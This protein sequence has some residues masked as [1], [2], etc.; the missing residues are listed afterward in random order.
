M[1]GNREV[2]DVQI[3]GC[4]GFGLFGAWLVGIVAAALA[5]IPRG[6]IA[7]GQVT[8]NPAVIWGV[9]S[10]VQR[11]WIATAVTWLAV[12]SLGVAAWLISH[13]FSV[14]RADD[15][16]LVPRKPAGGWLSTD[17]RL[18]LGAP[19]LVVIGGIAGAILIS[20]L[21][22]LVLAVPLA[23]GPIAGL[24]MGLS[25]TGAEQ[26]PGDRIILGAPEGDDRHWVATR[27]DMSAFLL[28][29]PSSGKTGGL[30]IPNLLA[31]D[32][33]A[34]ATSTKFDVLA[35]TARRRLELGGCWVWAPLDAE[36]ALPAGVHRLDYSPI[37][38]AENWGV[39]SRHAHA[40]AYSSGDGESSK[41]WASSA[42][43][44][45]AAALHAAAISGE[46]MS[47]VLEAIK[48]ADWRW[49]RKTLEE[50][51][52]ANPQARA[53]L[54]SLEGR[55]ATFRADMSAN[56]DQALSLALSG[57]LVEH[58]GDT[59]DWREFLGGRSTL[60]IV[61]PTELP[62]VDPAPWVNVLLAD[63]VYSVRQASAANG[64]RL[65][66][67][68]LMLLDELGALCSLDNL[69]SL[70]ATQRA[71]GMSFLLAAQSLAQIDRRYGQSGSRTIRDAVGAIVLGMG[72]SDDQALRDMEELVGGNV[73]LQQ[74]K[75]RADDP[76]V[77]EDEGARW[78]KHE[79]ASLR[80]YH[81]YA[82]L[83]GS[84]KPRHVR[85]P[86]FLDPPF[87]QLW[88]G[89]APVKGEEPPEGEAPEEEDG[90]LDFT[91][92]TR[93]VER[94]G[95]AMARVPALDRAANAWVGWVEDIWTRI[96]MPGLQLQLA[97]AA[98]QLEARMRGIEIS[99]RGQGINLAGLNGIRPL[100]AGEE[101]PRHEFS[102]LEEDGSISKIE[103]AGWPQSRF[104]SEAP[105]TS[106][107]CAAEEDND[108]LEDDDD[109]FP[110]SDAPQSAKSG[111]ARPQKVH[112]AALGPH[113]P[114]GMI[115]LLQQA[116]KITIDV[117]HTDAH[118]V[119]D[120]ADGGRQ[121]GEAGA[122]EGAGEALAGGD[123]AALVKHGEDAGQGLGAPMGATPGGAT[124]GEERTGLIGRALRITERPK[125]VGV[126][127]SHPDHQEPEWATAQREYD[128]RCQLQR[129]QEARAGAASK[130]RPMRWDP[131]HASIGIDAEVIEPTQASTAP[132]PA[133]DPGPATEPQRPDTPASPQPPPPSDPTATRR[134]ASFAVE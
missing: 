89:S 101:P 111:S 8:Q 72:V 97:S 127:R 93:L 49:L 104:H 64:Y 73:S 112:N 132:D 23:A 86:Y 11:F 15:P 116:R 5:G 120:A 129:E 85:A 117:K 115:Q 92:L 43:Q 83:K 1:S 28:G 123:E 47:R 131:G 21:A 38:G 74:R 13:R 118:E 65:P 113:G 37:S 62:H 79:I 30:I 12:I 78:A 45:I 103:V 29:S 98:E 108:G 76:K 66:H 26:I 90:R 31:W 105:Q 44:L 75:G 34:V 82:H 20:P 99:H 110:A 130:P 24:L 61:L 107:S 70:I 54:A 77:I 4:I 42:A 39:A 100:M 56:V 122:D 124:A 9:T 109:V 68:L 35:E 22:G 58:A 6:Q 59:L 17:P 40:L 25:R 121:G 18:V 46:G 41:V 55:N 3:K 96:T 69:D 94:G 128:V 14:G 57:Q 27:P 52:A 48:Q 134:H 7:V 63:L 36:F 84:D 32:G 51:P 81:F 2:R 91:W 53:A 102:V 67:R 19:A 133:T 60:W 126:L 87:R 114:S 16:F 125:R 80:Q 10:D 119:A 71:A 50:T 106:K 95:R 33:A 88:E